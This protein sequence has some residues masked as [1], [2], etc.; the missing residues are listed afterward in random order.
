L[1]DIIKKI[2]KSWLDYRKHCIDESTS[3]YEVKV[4]KGA[5]RRGLNSIIK[6]FK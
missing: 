2:S 3:G 1:K 4:V 5:K 6:D